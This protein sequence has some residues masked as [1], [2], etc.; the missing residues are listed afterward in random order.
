MKKSTLISAF[1]GF[2]LGSTIT[3]LTGVGLS[4]L[5]WW[6]IVIPTVILVEWAKQTYNNENN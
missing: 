6:I 3:G 5:R 1:W 4:D 2:Y